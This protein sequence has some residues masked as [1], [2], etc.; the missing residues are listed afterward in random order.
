MMINS[1]DIYQYMIDFDN[2]FSQLN[3]ATPLSASR[4][5]I[6]SLYILYIYGFVNVLYFLL[7]FSYVSILPFV[8]FLSRMIRMPCFKNIT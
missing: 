6:Y 1:L 4:I 5:S 2:N 3:V 7:S 8:Y